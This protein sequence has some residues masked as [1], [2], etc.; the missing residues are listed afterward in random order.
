MRLSFKVTY[1]QG[2]V[3]LKEV[4]KRVLWRA[5]NKM[6]ELATRYVPVNEG[7]L[8]ASIKLSPKYPGA[9]SYILSVGVDY[10]IH[11][12]FGTRPHWIPIKPLKEWSRLVLGD[13]DAAYAVQAAIAKRGTRAQPFMRPAYLQVKDFWLEIFWN[14]EL[15]RAQQSL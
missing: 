2:D 12:E 4:G 3:D 10:G 1:E 8:K 11:L 14:E 9:V 6:H 5:M 13:E 15:A 7:A